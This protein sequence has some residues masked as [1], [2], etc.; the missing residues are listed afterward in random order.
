MPEGQGIYYEKEVI[1]TPQGEPSQKNYA[2]RTEQQREGQALITNSNR[3]GA[4]MQPIYSP[5][6]EGALQF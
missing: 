2:Q 1:A 5:K 6:E 4:D 3:A